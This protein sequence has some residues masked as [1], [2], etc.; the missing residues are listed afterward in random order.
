M[1][2]ST[3]LILIISLIILVLA[4][5]GTAFAKSVHEDEVVFGG[6][7]TLRDGETLTGNLLVFGGN[8]SLEDGSL[9]NGDVILM[10]G[11][12]QAAGEIDGNIVTFGGNINLT[13]TAVVTGDVS[14]IG[15]NVDQAPG[16]TI[17][18]QVR[19]QARGPFFIPGGVRVPNIEAFSPFR[20]FVDLVWFL[21]LTF[22]FAAL[23]VLVVMFLPRQVERTAQTAVQSPLVAGGV[24]LLTAIVAP[25]LLVILAIT[26]L[27]IPVSLLGFLLLV[28]AWAFGLIALGTEVGRRLETSLNQNWTPA[29]SAGIGT[30]ILVLVT[31]GIGKIPCVGWIAPFLVGILGLGAAVLTRFGTA[32]YPL[33]PVVYSGPLQPPEPLRGDWPPAPPAPIQPAAPEIV[34]SA[35]YTARAVNVYPIPPAE[36]A[37]PP[38]LT[39]EVPPPVRKEDDLPPETIV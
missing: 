21:F 35:P 15:G 12:V 18:G 5:P 20:F 16:A 2:Y 27:L 26:I 24:G 14:T 37:P 8:A 3:R 36:E 1:K 34:E 22:L 32:S 7:F 9:V 10:G 4:L 30:F 31:N 11:N 23:A 6:S 19:D 28:I 38:T 29:V 25:L 33:S 39:G 17:E 13:D